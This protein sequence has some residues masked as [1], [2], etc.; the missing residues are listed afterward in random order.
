MHLTI[1]TIVF[2]VLTSWINTLVR[3]CAG[4]IQS[5]FVKIPGFIFVASIGIAGQNGTDISIAINLNKASA[6]RN[7]SADAKNDGFE[8]LMGNP[9]GKYIITE[10]EPLAYQVWL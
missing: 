2:T 10:R 9:D 4:G 5:H 7:S 6:T 3:V 8:R 1:V